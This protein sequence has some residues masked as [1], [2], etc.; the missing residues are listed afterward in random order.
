MIGEG[1]CLQGHH[2]VWEQNVPRS[3]PSPGEPLCGGSWWNLSKSS[4]SPRVPL[5]LSEK[6][7]PSL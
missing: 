6:L 5:R 4:T 3:A 2:P 7:L 1:R